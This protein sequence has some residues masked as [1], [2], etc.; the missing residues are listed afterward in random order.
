[1]SFTQP[2]A[3]SAPAPVDT[4]Y[5]RTEGATAGAEVGGSVREHR[6]PAPSPNA[7]SARADTVAEGECRRIP[8]EIASVAAKPYSG[9]PHRTKR[10][11]RNRP[12]EGSRL[13]GTEAYGFPNPGRLYMP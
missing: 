12:A 8:A 11:T 10:S 3:S 2:Q 5:S 6:H 9:R 4:R 13:C 1:M 7:S